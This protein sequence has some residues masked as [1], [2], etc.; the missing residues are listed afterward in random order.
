[1]QTLN[2]AIKLSNVTK[3]YG[4]NVILKGV[5]LSINEGEFVCIR[6]KSGVGKTSLFKYW[7]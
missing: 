2:L 1:M 7:R 5:N 3:T 6:G 4:S